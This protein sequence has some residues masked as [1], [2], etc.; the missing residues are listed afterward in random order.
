MWVY[1]LHSF[2]NLLFKN[3]DFTLPNSLEEEIHIFILYLGY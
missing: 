1:F 3:N 2:N